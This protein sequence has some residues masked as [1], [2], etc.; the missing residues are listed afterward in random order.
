VKYGKETLRHHAKELYNEGKSS[1]KAIFLDRDGTIN[2]DVGDLFSGDRLSILPNAF[3][4]LRMLQRHFLLFI[5]TN[6]SG[7]GKG[8][9]SEAQYY[10]FSRY[11]EKCLE[12]ES[13][14]IQRTY[15]CPHRKEERCLCRK[16]DP[17][18]LFQAESEY[19]VDLKKSYVVGDHPQDIEMAHRAGTGSVY[20]LS[21][22]GNKH[23][24]E[25]LQGPD[26]V[27]EDI[28]MAARWI[29]KTTMNSTP[30]EQ[31]GT[32]YGPPV[33]AKAH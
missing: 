23:R 11:F 32:S 30:T 2:E 10:A 5:V 25:I 29:V 18:F 6:Q 8:S 20:V 16:P 7:I 26:I 12:N 31:L 24:H 19:G 22:H 17:Y 33:K 13:I 15:C 3:E 9:F 21:G 1:N 4:A 14:V 28:Y 27:V